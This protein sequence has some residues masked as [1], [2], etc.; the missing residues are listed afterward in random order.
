MNFIVP[1]TRADGTSATWIESEDGKGDYRPYNLSLG[2]VLVFA[3]ANL[4][5]GNHPNRTG[6]NRL[7]MDFRAL[8]MSDYVPDSHKTINTGIRFVIGGYWVGPT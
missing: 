4:R 7:S 1:F 3:G 6:Q 2:E 8:R 5:H